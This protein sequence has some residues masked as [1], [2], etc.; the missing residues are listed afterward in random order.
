LALNQVVMMAMS[1]VIISGMIG[2]Q[3]LGFKTVEALTKPD[4]GVGVE[5]GLALL[6]MAIILDRLSES[7]ADLFSRGETPR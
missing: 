2:G 5:S 7:A 1:M 4:T 6:V 3:G